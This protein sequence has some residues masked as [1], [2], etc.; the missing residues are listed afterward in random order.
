MVLF[1]EANPNTLKYVPICC[2]KQRDYHRARRMINNLVINR[3]LK[4]SRSILQLLA[5]YGFGLRIG[6]E[7]LIKALMI[8]KFHM[9]LLLNWEYMLEDWEF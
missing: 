5:R 9:R 4:R 3:I 6:F 2:R 8:R 7:S 1:I